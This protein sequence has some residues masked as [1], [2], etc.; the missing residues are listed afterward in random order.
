MLIVFLHQVHAAV[1]DSGPVYYET[2]VRSGIIEPWN[3]ISSLS[4][5]MPACWFL[6]KCYPK[7][8]DFPFLIFFATP[9]LILG[10]I[11]STLYH[12]FRSSNVLMWLDVAPVFVLTLSLGTYFL[13]LRYRNIYFASLFLLCFIVIRFLGFSIFE[14][15]TA[16]NVSYFLTGVY[17]F[18]PAILL[19]QN[20]N[21]RGTGLIGI[22]AFLFGFALLMRWNDDFETQFFI[23][24]THWLW[25]I[26]SAA[27]ALFLGEFLLSSEKIIIHES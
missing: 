8:R 23:S 10:G 14:L 3:A 1:R 15:Q 16:I 13:W 18:I 7:Y 2:A 17:I 22:S 21:F 20:L 4:Y 5:L 26:F 9:L 19:L 25:H 27:G 24:G 11:G 6:L 12:A